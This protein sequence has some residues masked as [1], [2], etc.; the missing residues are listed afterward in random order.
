[1][2][3]KRGSSSVKGG[4]DST[5]VYSLVRSRGCYA[6]FYGSMEEYYRFVLYYRPVVWSS[7]IEIVL[8]GSLLGND[9]ALE[10]L[11]NSLGSPLQW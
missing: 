7:S 4:K 11:S 10:L 3:D 8:F 5:G 6:V 9:G 1:M 2:G